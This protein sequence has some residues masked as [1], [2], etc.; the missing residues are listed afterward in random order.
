[1][2]SRCLGNSSLDQAI[3][4][5]SLELFL[6]LI[7]KTFLIMILYSLF[8]SRF[9][10]FSHSLFYLK[11]IFLFSSLVFQHLTNKQTE[12][13]C[14]STA[15]TKTSETQHN[16]QT[17]KKLDKNGTAPELKE[18]W[19]FY[20][21]FVLSWWLFLHL[22]FWLAHTHTLFQPLF[23]SLSP[24]NSSK[25]TSKPILF[26]T[27]FYVRAACDAIIVCLWMFCLSQRLI[28]VHVFARSVNFSS[29]KNNC[30]TKTN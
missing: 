11:Y 28:H 30:K 2:H 14:D 12:Q 23:F 9:R 13:N 20:A 7:L 18:T 21:V 25:S 24:L 22:T 29:Y 1:M 5:D 15:K 4:L 19:R 16:A 10:S 8:W 6:Y 17:E 26:K 3:I 27:A